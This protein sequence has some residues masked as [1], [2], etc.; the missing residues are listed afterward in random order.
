[1]NDVSESDQNRHGTIG[2]VTGR[3]FRRC[4]AEATIAQEFVTVDRMVNKHSI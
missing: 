4:S 2:A 3:A 1:M